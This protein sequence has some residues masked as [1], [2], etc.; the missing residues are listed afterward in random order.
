MSVMIHLVVLTSYT[1]NASPKKPRYVSQFLQY[2]DCLLF[3]CFRYS[4]Q[5]ITNLG[6]ASYVA[7]CGSPTRG[8]YLFFHHQSNGRHPYSSTSE[9]IFKIILFLDCSR[10]YF[11]KIFFSEQK[12]VK[13]MTD[14]T[15][16]T[17]ILSS[18]FRS[19][20]KYIFEKIRY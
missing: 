13:I 3:L 15:L 14:G 5:H 20:P 19:R 9:Y 1:C 17:K 11:S 10:E 16:L 7:V 8:H 2:T 12:S 4:V 6:P 18:S